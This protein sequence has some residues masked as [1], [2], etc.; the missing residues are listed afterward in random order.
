MRRTTLALALLAF[1][2][3][4]V[5][6]SGAG[7]DAGTSSGSG[8][9]AAHG[10]PGPPLESDP[11]VLETSL[12]CPEGLRRPD[13][14]V[15]LLVHGTA[16]TATET[17]PSG[18]G[19][20]LTDAG[21]DWCTVQ[22]PGR[23][24]VDIQQSAEHV[25]AAVRTLNRRTGRKV[26]IVG[27]SQGA[28]QPRW[29]VRWWPDVR[30]GVDDLVTIAG[31]NREIPWTKAAFCH[32]SCNPPIW[33]FSAGARFMEVL[34]R[35]PMPAG[36]SYTTIRSHTDNLIQPSL[37]EAAAV[38]TI[39]GA[40]NIAVQDLCPGRVVEHAGLVFDAVA[41]AVV[42]DALT[43]PDAAAD[44]VRVGNAECA[45]VYATGIDPVIA[46]AAI[47]TLYANAFPAVPAGPQVDSEPPL[48]AYAKG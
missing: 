2:A 32:P 25:V 27:H 12:D 39:D 47:T 28:L 13:Q 6:G 42:M 8:A 18:L 16:T 38:A 17:W 34:N 11:V 48:R 15:V 30:A 1:A 29:A 44:P 46:T 22:L 37:P 4:I 3:A 10:S 35:V 31:A 9:G 21:F 19:R 41:L 14:N 40:V 24:L 20:V 5:P 7:A 33:Q 26:S 36:P 43:H 23:A 45:Q